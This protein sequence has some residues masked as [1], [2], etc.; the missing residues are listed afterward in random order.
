MSHENAHAGPTLYMIW[1]RGGLWSLYTNH[2]RIYI[3]QKMA[4]ETLR[5]WVQP[6]RNIGPGPS[7]SLQKNNG[8]GLHDN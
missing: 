3:I 2:A 6:P 8:V 4:D 1:E 5:L 7:Y